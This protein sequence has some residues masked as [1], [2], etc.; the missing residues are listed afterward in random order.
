MSAHAG[1]VGTKRVGIKGDLG[2]HKCFIEIEHILHVLSRYKYFLRELIRSKVKDISPP[3]H[4]KKCDLVISNHLGWP[5]NIG[6]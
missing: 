4:E 3:A 2:F 6:F 1:L 5:L